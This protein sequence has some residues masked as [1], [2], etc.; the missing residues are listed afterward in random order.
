[1]RGAEERDLMFGRL[2]GY[3]ALIRSGRCCSIEIASHTATRLIDLSKRKVWIREVVVDALLQLLDVHPSPG[4]LS[5]SLQPL[6]QGS[7]DEYSPHQLQLLLG[8]QAYLSRHAVAK[9]QKHT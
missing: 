6:L 7:I 8:V 1:M 3:L 9:H 2:F 4:D 5:P